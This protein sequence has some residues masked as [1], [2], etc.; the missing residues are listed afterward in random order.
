MKL[1]IVAGLLVL[2]VPVAWF[3][4]GQIFGGVPV[5]TA[6]VRRGAIVEYI[7]EQ[8]QT[9]LPRT[10]LITMPYEARLLPIELEEGTPVSKG[11]VVA[12][13]VPADLAA[14]VAEATAAVERLDASIRE[15]GDHHVEESL[16][17]QSLKYLQSMDRTVEAGEQQVKASDARLTYANKNLDRLR[18]LMPKNA[19]SEE[20]LNRAQ[21]D[22]ADAQVQYQRDVLLVRSLEAL[23]AA[24]AIAPPTV[25]QYIQRKELHG[26]VLARERAEAAA[27]LDQVLRRQQRGTM[28][29]PVDGVVLRR[30]VSDERFLA[31]GTV[32]LEI[33]QPDEVEVEAEVLSQDAGRIAAGNAV[34]VYGPAI[35]KPDAGGVVR[36]ID[37]A[38]F[39]K[40]SSLGVEQ[41]RVKVFVTLDTADRARLRKDR[42][43]G[44][45][46]RVRVRIHTAEKGDALL[47]PRSALF[48]SA[49]G[50]WQTY[51]IR[52][53]RATLQTVQ[54]GLSNDDV[55]EV[56][57]GLAAGEAVIVA[58]ET[59]LTSGVR[60][61]PNLRAGGER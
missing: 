47:L 54:I 22:Q 44:V 61:L 6:E 28:T 51:V 52:N 36:R 16:H 3:G 39:T 53:S 13:V 20:D 29:S 18:R 37:P 48:R 38:G 60:V 59:N 25:Q 14:Q 23:R 24:V 19:A 46:Y 11:Q 32:L 2:L 33:G 10:Y 43:L 8:A 56:T 31:G 42:Q 58:P 55:A 21:W 41:Q 30:H 57:Q 9:R 35:G 12:Q 4:Y 40:L 50:E 15:N 1:R 34:T 26:A 49:G 5:D 27:R 17:E 45:G 7:D